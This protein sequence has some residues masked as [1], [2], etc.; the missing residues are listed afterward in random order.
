LL[1]RDFRF[2]GNKLSDKFKEA[3][4][5]ELSIL[6][7]AGV[8]IK[9]TLELLEKQQRKPRNR[10][11]V[12]QVKEQIIAGHSLSDAVKGTGQFSSYEY[13]SL[14][15]G[16][17][18]GKIAGVLTDLAAYY[19]RKL[20]QRRQIVQALSYPVIVLCT[21]VGAIAFMMNFI[22]PM[23]ADVFKRFGGDLPY[24][25]Q[26]IISFSSTVR[27]YAWLLLL[28]LVGQIVAYRFLKNKTW[29]RHYGSRLVM[30]TPIIGDIV[31]RV[32]LAQ[33]CGSF[34]LLVGAKVPLLQSI[35]LIRQMIG[36]YPIQS[37]LAQVEKD[38]MQGESLHRSLSRFPIYDAR[39]IAL[40]KVGEEVN[41]LEFFLGRLSS[42]YNEEIEHQ[43]S[44]LSSAI[45]PFIIIFLGL[46][47]GLILVAMYLPLLELSTNLG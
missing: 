23:F 42:Q 5:L 33:F 20:K 8:D 24:I 12:A 30:G 38:I 29:F 10:S 34:T 6:I 25:T 37:S 36:F 17:E 40:L 28:L 45:E 27:A 9:A 22:V 47:V 35:A 44:L 1:N 11:L 13:F 32:Y 39:M 15:I 2:G 43:A 26:V 7:S 41:K 3:F 18:T 16:E 14:Q 31:S 19:T 46:I 21:S 4:Y